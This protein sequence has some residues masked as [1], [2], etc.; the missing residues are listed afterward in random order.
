MSSSFRIVASIATLSLIATA[1]NDGSKV[2]EDVLAQDSSLVREVMNANRDSISPAS[3]DNL[4]TAV[5]S[6]ALSAAPAL[7]ARTPVAEKPTSV[8]PP[9]NTTRSGKSRP[10]SLPSASRVASAQDIRDNA[11][12][13]SSTK[14]SAPAKHRVVAR[15]SAGT[16]STSGDT[17]RISP[18]SRIQAREAAAPKAAPRAVALIPAGSD[19][20]FTSD[21]RVCRSTSSVGDTF[22]ARV[23]EDVIG[24]LGV[25]VP[26]GSVATAQVFT[27]RNDSRNNP[28]SDVGI[29]IQSVTVAGHTYEIASLVTSSDVTEVRRSR[30]DAGK[31]IAGAGL[32]AVLG[33][34][35]GHDTRSTIIGAVGG[36]A[37]G[38]VVARQT[39]KTESCIPDGG[40][41]TAKL[42]EPLRVAFTE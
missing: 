18:A 25:V 42:T 31:V 4:A 30:N 23:A 24:P 40:R 16:S 28:E 35:L 8:R 11:V 19:I 14:V 38:A 3:D 33:R 41:I 7:S 34:V 37:T 9:L 22:T 10:A 5:Q 12:R 32:G 15:T 2:T 36:A 21:D 1:C 39:Q 17:D 13:R 29:R 27:K 26:K 20:E 6:G